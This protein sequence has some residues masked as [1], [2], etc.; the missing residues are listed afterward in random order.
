MLDAD[1]KKAGSFPGAAL[2]L[3]G[4]AW[5]GAPTSS[6]VLA[7]CR[8]LANV[9]DTLLPTTQLFEGILGQL[10]PQYVYAPNMHHTFDPSQVWRT[11]GTPPSKLYQTLGQ[12][13]AQYFVAHLPPSLTEW[14]AVRNPETYTTE[15]GLLIWW[16][17]EDS[18]PTYALQTPMQG[19]A[20]I[21]PVDTNT[22]IT[23]LHTQGSTLIRGID[24][25]SAPGLL[26]VYQ[27]PAALFED[28]ALLGA[29]RRRDRC[30]TSYSMGMPSEQPSRFS[31]K[32]ARHDQSVW[33]LQA[34]AAEYCGL[35]VFPADTEILEVQQRGAGY[36]YVTR[37]GQVEAAYDHTSLSV[38]EL[39][40][41]GQVVGGG[42]QL[43]LGSEYASVPWSSDGLS[44]DGFCPVAGLRAPDSDVTVDAENET[45]PNV[46]A[47][48]HLEGDAEDQAAYWA[49][50][51]A[52]EVATG[53][54]LND[55]IGLSDVDDTTTVNPITLIFRDFLRG[56]GVIFC[57]DETVFTPARIARLRQFLE[58]RAPLGQPC[59]LHMI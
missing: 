50:T 36:T 11:Y 52:N 46:H 25:E 3:T 54:Y 21:I 45:G 38:G 43:F 40:Q 28:H 47:R 41:E 4:S 26:M 56:A 32:Y 8:T 24:F 18:P 13:D 1:V 51:E 48:L 49:L 58:T 7:Q 31:V 30:A 20:W 27:D 23:R 10:R 59:F 55:L 12:E 37:D 34:A 16:P 2:G 39:V 9:T 19:E 57:L 33:V 14:D 15:D 6:G 35:S 5:S 53:Q 44:L 42:I 29:G 22:E 17:M